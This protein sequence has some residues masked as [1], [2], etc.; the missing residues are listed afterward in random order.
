MRWGKIFID[1]FSMITLAAIIVMMVVILAV[2]L[3]V[4]K[5]ILA[6]AVPIVGAAGFIIYLCAY[7][8]VELSFP[9]ALFRSVFATC[10]MF[11]GNNEFEFIEMSVVMQSDWIRILFWI[12]HNIAIMMSAGIVFTTFG[13]GLLSRLRLLLLRR[14]PVAVLYGINEQSLTFGEDLSKQKHEILVYVDEPD[15]ISFKSRI[16]QLSAVMQFN[17]TEQKLEVRFLHRL[18][19]RPGKRKI[20]LYALSEN[21]IQ[22]FAYADR[23]LNAAGQAGV[24]QDQLSLVLLGDEASGALLQASDEKYGYASVLALDEATMAARMLIRHYPPCQQISFDANGRAKNDINA[25]ILGFGEV[26]QAVLRHLVMNGQFEGSRFSLAIFDPRY[27]DQSGAMQFEYHALLKEYNIA[28]YGHD[29]RSAALFSYLKE[30]R[31]SVNY[32]VICTG[33]EQMNLEIEGKLSGYLQYL[34]CSAPIFCVSHNGV[35]HHISERKEEKY[36]LYCREALT[37]GHMDHMAMVLN[38]TYSKGKSMEDDWLHCDYFS[39]MS[40]RAA[41]DFALAMLRMSGMTANQLLT[42]GW[43]IEGELLENMARTEHLRWCAFHY[44]M[45]YETMPEK[46]WQ[47]RKAA[48][49]DEISKFGASNIRISR[50]RSQRQHACLIPWEQLPELSEK[51]NAVTGKHINYQQSDRDNVLAM[52]EVLKIAMAQQP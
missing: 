25:L 49:L 14:R 51:E 30:N 5:K 47:Q 20:I 45:G 43:K 27:E 2:D 37:Y 38:H 4:I 12:L 9:V 29:G 16:Q 31:N 33:N 6:V 36:P 10:S 50:D 24:N 46:I 41:A 42:D 13:T 44:A 40:S 21:S 48:F 1:A 22:N 3:R 52:G 11:L 17:D 19:I 28:F 7:Y 39:R 26:G 32:I 23:F 15:K 8:D 34:Q 35:K 18:G